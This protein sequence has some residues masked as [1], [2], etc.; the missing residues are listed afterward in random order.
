MQINLNFYQLQDAKLFERVYPDAKSLHADAATIV[1]VLHVES[2]IQGI[3]MN[4]NVVCGKREN[5]EVESIQTIAN[6]G[7]DIH[8]R[9]VAVSP[10]LSARFEKVLKMKHIVQRQI[11]LKC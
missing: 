8:Y 5:K 4:Q 7:Q 6:V 9:T 2:I 3:A 10:V 1:Q 11:I